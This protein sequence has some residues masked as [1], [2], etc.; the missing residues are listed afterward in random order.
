MHGASLE[1]YHYWARV[2]REE[3]EE[4]HHNGGRGNN[5]TSMLVNRCTSKLFKLRRAAAALDE[6]PP[7]VQEEKE[8]GKPEVVTTDLTASSPQ[9]E[10]LSPDH[11]EELDVHRALRL[12]SVSS[13]TVLILTDVFGPISSPYAVSTVGLVPGTILYVVVCP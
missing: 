12:A 9:Y 13:V 7:V 4:D 11:V 1:E 6:P 3:E 10:G 5:P 2:Q 8:A